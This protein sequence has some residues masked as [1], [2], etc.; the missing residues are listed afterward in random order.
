MSTPDIAR[1]PL[2][3]PGHRVPE[4]TYEVITPAFRECIDPVARLER[5]HT[6][7]RWTEGPVYFAD[8]KTLVWSDIPNRQMLSLAELSGHVSLYRAAT[9]HA[10]GNTR[11]LQG[12]LITCEHSTRRVIRTEHDGSVTVLAERFEGKRLNSPNDVVV[13]SDGSIWFTDPNYGIASDF[14]GVRAEQEMSGCHVYRIDPCDGSTRIVAD[15]FVMP[16]GL[17]FSPDESRLYIADSGFL[18]DESSP[19]HIRVFDVRDDGSLAG[20][21]IFTT[22]SPGIPDGFRIDTGGRL[23][24]GAGDGVQCITPQGELIG[25]ILVPESSA[26]LAFGGPQRNRLY[27]TATSSLYAIDTRVTGAQR[28]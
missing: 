16:N 25:K 22:I 10:N 5:L 2:P 3:A 15:D 1:S 8:L 20:G 21:D 23:W 19:R 24:A 28:P 9:G 13:K 17:A 6:G 26:N 11:D 18:R 7:C 27:I 14:V 4:P 12:R